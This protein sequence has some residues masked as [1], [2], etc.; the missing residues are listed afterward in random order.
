MIDTSRMQFEL[1]A[2][3]RGLDIK[4]SIFAGCY[5]EPETQIAWDSW[6]GSREAV[7]VVLP[8]CTALTSKPEDERT[9]EVWNAALQA[10]A[11]RI[12]AVGVKVSP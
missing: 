9:A 6:R 1:W 5:A 7:V 8:T 10:T 3:D 4:D 12:E 11:I 2:E